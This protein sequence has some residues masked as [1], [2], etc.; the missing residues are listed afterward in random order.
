VK[1]GWIA[2]DP[3]YVGGA[4]LTQAEFRAAAPVEVVD[5][6][7]DDLSA[8]EDCEAVVVHNCV[9]YPP[10]T[11]EALQGKRVVRYWHDLSRHGSTALREWLIA[12]ATHI[13][14]SPLHLA[15]HDVEGVWPT[16]PPAMDVARMR[17][18]RQVRRNGHRSGTCCIAQW[19]NPGKGGLLLAD[20]ARRNGPVDV[21]GDGDFIPHAPNLIHRG[22]LDPARV[23]EV[24]WGYERFVF[25]PLEPEPFCRSVVEAH[26]AGCE[27][28]TNELIGARY[29]LEEAPERLASAA[30]DFWALVAEK[31]AA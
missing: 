14:T 31:V 24:L 29:Y 17:P 1:V 11:I 19:R 20:W 10:E 8:A 23:P 21:Y 18:T 27:V 13:F 4:E 2:H 16:I 30:E 25:L 22:S 12:N 26:F 9:T 15:R 3:G 5:I 6:P 28:I 7:P